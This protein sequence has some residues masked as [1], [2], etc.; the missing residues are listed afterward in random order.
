MFTLQIYFKLQCPNKRTYINNTK[1]HN[2]VNQRKK[3]QY[4][5]FNKQ[6][7]VEP[8]KTKQVNGITF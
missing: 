7:L 8:I 4:D 5:L 3:T 1:R 2:E 6:F